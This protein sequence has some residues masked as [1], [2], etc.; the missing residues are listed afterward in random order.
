M[1]RPDSRALGTV[2]LAHGSLGRGFTVAQATEGEAR[3]ALALLL[4]HHSTASA[5][6]V[7]RS[8]NGLWVAHGFIPG[9]AAAP[10]PS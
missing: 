3:T 6:P 2:F 1:S 5:G 8:V 10:V 7:H 9:R 4:A